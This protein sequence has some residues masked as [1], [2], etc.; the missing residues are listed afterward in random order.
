M[1]LEFFIASFAALFVII[2]TLVCTPVF[3][4]RTKGMI[5]Q[6]M[7]IIAL[8]SIAVSAF[9]FLLFIIFIETV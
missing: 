6:V 4:V 3:I 9:V 8:R 7:Q 1:D 2:V 5:R